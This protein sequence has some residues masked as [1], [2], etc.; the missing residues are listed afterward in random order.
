MALNAENMTPLKI[1][2]LEVSGHMFTFIFFVEMV[3]KMVAFRKTY[4]NNSWN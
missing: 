2:L 1:M 3:L 4:F